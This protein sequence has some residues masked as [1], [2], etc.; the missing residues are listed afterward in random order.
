MRP[1]ERDETK[2]SS[3]VQEAVSD[4]L[5]PRLSLFQDVSS[6]ELQALPAELCS[7]PT[8]RDLNV[9][10]NQLSSLPDGEGEEDLEGVGGCVCMCVY[11]STL[12]NDALVA[13]GFAMCE[14]H[15]KLF[16]FLLASTALKP[17]RQGFLAVLTDVGKGRGGAGGG[18]VSR[19]PVEL[20]VRKGLRAHPASPLNANEA[21]K[22]LVW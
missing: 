7:L 15:C 16:S 22:T 17:A 14:M 4:A 11:V 18:C 8:L 3:L 2:G 9:R 1:R 13:Q 20:Q 10:R 6:N 21:L 5:C 19:R 12:N